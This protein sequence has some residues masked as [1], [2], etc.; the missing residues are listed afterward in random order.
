MLGLHAARGTPARRARRAG[1]EPRIGGR[2]SAWARRFF[3][4]GSAVGK[5][6][7]E[8]GCTTCPWTTVV[9]VVSDVKYVGLDQPDEG[10]V[11]SPMSGR[12]VAVRRPPDARRV[13]RP[14]CRRLRARGPR[15]R[16]RRAALERRHD[17]RAG[18]AVADAAAVAVDARRELRGHRARAVDVRD[19]RRDGVLRPAAPEGHQHSNGARRGLVR[20]RAP[21]RRPGHEGRG[22][23]GCARSRCRVRPRAARGQPVIWRRPRGSAGLP[24]RHG[25]CC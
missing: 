11:Y 6:F 10:T 13:R 9:G 16:S 22:A 3:P 7:R 4:N 8:G 2:R 18:R 23:G 17:R 1:A 12:A 25:A 5:R 24:R 15:D 20:R 19:L 21:D 14:C